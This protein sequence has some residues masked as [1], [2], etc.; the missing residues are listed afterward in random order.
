[1]THLSFL[2]PYLPLVP[3]LALAI[4]AMVLLM[5][6]VVSGER[7]ARTVNGL[8]VWLLAGIAVLVLMLPGGRHSL[9]EGAFVVDDF[10]RFLKLLVLAGSAGALILSLD[11]LVKE[12]QQKFEYGPLVLLSTLGMMVLIS[13]GDLIALYLGLELMSLALYVVAAFHRDSIRSTQRRSGLTI[14]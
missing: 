13:A 7:S 6:G 9:F 1:M 10:A 2:G 12:R 4:G 5:L 11:Y 14:S 3:E 8:S